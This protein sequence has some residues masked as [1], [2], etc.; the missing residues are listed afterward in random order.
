MSQKVRLNKAFCDYWGLVSS[1]LSLLHIPENQTI[2]PNFNWRAICP[3]FKWLGYRNSDPTNLLQ[4]NLVLT[5]RKSRLVWISDAH[6][7]SNFWSTPIFAIPLMPLRNLRMAP[8]LKTVV[9]VKLKLT[10]GW[11]G[12]KLSPWTCSLKKVFTTSRFWLVYI[13]VDNF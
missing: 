12:W 6:C 10:A 5:I 13:N 2:C 8:S 1:A 11:S 4:P 3:D 7:T 9:Q